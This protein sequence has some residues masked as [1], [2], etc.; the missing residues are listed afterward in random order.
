MNVGYGPV[1]R[2]VD[3]WCARRDAKLDIDALFT[4]GTLTPHMVLIGQLGL[5]YIEQEWLRYRSDVAGD[6]EGLSIAK[7]RHAAATKALALA[8]LELREGTEPSDEQLTRR[9]GGEERTAVSVIRNR[10]LAEHR[11]RAEDA[12]T[13]RQQLLTEW[14]QSQAA[15]GHLCDLV[16]ARF[17]LAQAHAFAA[18]GYVFRRR[19][20]YLSHL[21]RRHPDGKRIGQ[22][23]RADFVEGPQWMVAARAPDLVEQAG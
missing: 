8:E 22:L 18:A 11:R 4:I 10:R 7:A 1:T 19:T 17:G 6:L 23:T 12:A 14:E 2:G 13:R 16:Q 9:I 15:I 3:W 20:S 21:I 5:G